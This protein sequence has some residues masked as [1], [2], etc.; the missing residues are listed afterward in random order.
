M[1]INYLDAELQYVIDHLLLKESYTI[2]NVYESEMN[3]YIIY[4][5]Y[6]SN[7]NPVISQDKKIKTFKSKLNK[8]NDLTIKIHLYDELYT[9]TN[10]KINIDMVLS[11]KYNNLSI[12]ANT[13]CNIFVFGDKNKDLLKYFYEYEKISEPSSHYYDYYYMSL[14]DDKCYILHQKSLNSIP[15]VSG[16]IPDDKEII[17]N[18]KTIIGLEHNISNIKKIIGTRI[19]KIMIEY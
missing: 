10:G 13:S 2:Y 19:I 16:I 9:I 18:T 3:I 15:L 6:H 5:T 17:Y 7:Q 8:F 1:F 12:I 14:Q 4:R 11:N